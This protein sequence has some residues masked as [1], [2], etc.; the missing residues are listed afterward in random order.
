MTEGAANGPCVAEVIAAAKTSAPAAIYA[1]FVA[2]NSPVGRAVN[3]T[4]CRGA[5]C[6]QECDVP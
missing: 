3:V 6:P 1:Q 4:A 2:A 5:F